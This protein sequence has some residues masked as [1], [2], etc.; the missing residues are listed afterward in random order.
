MLSRTARAVQRILCLPSTGFPDCSDDRVEKFP[1]TGA[2]FPVP[3]NTEFQP[4]MRRKLGI[5][6][7]SFTRRSFKL[8][9]K[10]PFFF[11]A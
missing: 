8:G 10:I 2:N 5:S 3:L 7:G 9:K 6:A 4:K 1:V 11:P